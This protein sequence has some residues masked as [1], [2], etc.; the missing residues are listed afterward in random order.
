L[1]GK[2][3]KILGWHICINSV[4]KWPDAFTP[5]HPSSDDP[6][7]RTAFRKELSHN[8]DRPV[9]SHKNRDV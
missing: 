9:K 2:N 4:K 8:S 5:V 3:I 1:L 7:P 6:W